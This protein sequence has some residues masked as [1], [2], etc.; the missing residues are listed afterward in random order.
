VFEDRVLRRMF[1]SKRD[2]VIGG[3]GK[4]QSEQLHNWHSSPNIIRMIESMRMRWAGHI[5][6]VGEK[7]NSY[8]VWWGSRTRTKKN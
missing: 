6:R 2:G 4:L 1:E 7:R 3:W 8:R 5:A